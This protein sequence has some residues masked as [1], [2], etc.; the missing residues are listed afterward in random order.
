MI[1]S[2]GA[3]GGHYYAYIKDFDTNLWYNFNDQTVQRVSTRNCIYTI[4]LIVINIITFQFI[5][6]HIF[7]FLDKRLLLQILRNHLAVLL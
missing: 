6:Y 7:D 4:Y 3:S 2:G 5:L 1:H